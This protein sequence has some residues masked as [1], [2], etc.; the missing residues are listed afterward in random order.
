MHL[1]SYCSP[2]HYIS[3]Q[4]SDSPKTWWGALHIAGMVSSIIHRAAAGFLLTLRAK[5]DLCACIC[6]QIAACFI[7]S[8]PKVLPAQKGGGGACT[9]LAWHAQA[10]T[11]LLQA[12]CSL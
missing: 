7:N 1:L 6:C 12:F 3:A 5:R 10:Y 8:V 2:F 9:L 4:G 11:E